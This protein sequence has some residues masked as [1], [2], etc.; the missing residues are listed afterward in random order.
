MKKCINTRLENYE[1]SEVCHTSNLTLNY[2][3]DCILLFSIL[4]WILILKLK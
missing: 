2:C 1:S 3:T 4:P